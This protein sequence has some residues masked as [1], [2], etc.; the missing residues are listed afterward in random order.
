M[1]PAAALARGLQELAL[2]LPAG[3]TERLLAYVA[4]LEKWNRTYNL[5]AIRDPLAMVSQHLLDSLAVRAE[6]PAG[7]LVDVGAGAGLPGIPLAIA[8]PQRRITLNEANE[9]KGAFLRQAVIELRLTNASVYIGR[10]ERWRPQPR[11]EIAICRGFA[12]LA[13]FIASCRHLVSPGGTLA[14]MKG[15]YPAAELAR[16]PQDCDCRDVRKLYVPLLD[17]DRHL[18]LCRA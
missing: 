5:T 11:F 4:L 7:T 16:V 12:S 13:E 3:A 15:I 9:K 6:L 2:E 14:A 18:V 10:V 17:A 8:E 1:T